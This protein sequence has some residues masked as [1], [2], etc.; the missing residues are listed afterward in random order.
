MLQK[1]LLGLLSKSCG[2]S[3][4]DMVKSLASEFG[5]KLEVFEPK[6]LE[7]RA[8]AF[9]S[10]SLFA[11]RPD[12]QVFH[13]RGTGPNGSRAEMLLVMKTEPGALEG[14]KILDAPATPE[15]PSRQSA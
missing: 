4:P 7:D 10:A 12:S 8:A 6:S 1:V 13:V 3:F 14:E 5:A 9:Q 15:I 2:N 11:S